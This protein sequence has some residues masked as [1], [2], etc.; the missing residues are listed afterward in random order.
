VP[1]SLASQLTCGAPPWFLSLRQ[2]YQQHKYV[3]TEAEAACVAI[4]NGHTDIDSGAVYHDALLQGV[5]QNHCSMDDVDA[6]LFNTLKLR[7][8]LGLFDPIEDQPYW[9]VRGFP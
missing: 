1:F 9:Q 5:Q 8:E 7:F 4:R 3:A 2:I 6:A